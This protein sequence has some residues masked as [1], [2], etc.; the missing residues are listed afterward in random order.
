MRMPTWLSATRPVRTLAMALTFTSLRNDVIRFPQQGGR[1]GKA[2]GPGRLQVDGQLEPGR[3]LHG[4]VCR[5][6][7]LEDLVDVAGASAE[8]VATVGAVRH[9]SSGVHELSEPVDGREPAHRREAHDP[10]D[11]GENQ[12]ILHDDE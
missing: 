4:Q 10:A 6:R 7:A 5:P 2:E 12:L 9:Q 3:G 1:N 8:Q 11:V